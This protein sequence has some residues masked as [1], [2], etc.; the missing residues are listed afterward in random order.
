MEQLLSKG[1]V[2][3]VEDESPFRRIYSDALVSYGYK[4][5]EA[6]TCAQGW[7]SMEDSCPDVVLLDLVFPQESGLDLLRKMRDHQTLFRVPVVIF[8]VFSE[9]KKIQECLD[10][11]AD[12]YAIKGQVTPPEIIG[13]IGTMMKSAHVPKKLQIV[14]GKR[15]RPTIRAA[16]RVRR[17]ARPRRASKKK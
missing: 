5:R 14:H 15:G 12:D 10:A 2:L 13:I 6:E 3:L 7:Q 8:S 9:E 1:I 17:T 4:V 11:G 16:G